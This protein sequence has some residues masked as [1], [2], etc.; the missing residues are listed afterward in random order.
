MQTMVSNPEFKEGPEGNIYEPEDPQVIAGYQYGMCVVSSERAGAKHYELSNHLGNVLAVISDHKIA[1][2]ATSD[3]LADYYLPDVLSMS[4]YYPF[5]SPMPGRMENAV[6]YRF[7]FNGQEADDEIYGNGNSYT[8]EFWQYDARLGRRWNVDPKGRP[9]ES[10]YASFANNPIIMIDPGGDSTVFYRADGTILFAM[11]STKNQPVLCVIPDDQLEAFSKAK[12]DI[13]KSKAYSSDNL[14]M[15]NYLRTLGNNYD[16]Q[17]FV[18]FYN[19]SEN[20]LNITEEKQYE[21]I[22]GKPIYNEVSAYLVSKVVNGFKLFQVGNFS[23][24]YGEGSPNGCGL[25]FKSLSVHTHPLE[26]RNFLRNGKPFDRTNDPPL[27]SNNVRATG[28]G[29][30]IGRSP[31]KKGTGLFDVNVGGRKD[32][33]L[34]NSSGTII[35]TNYDKFK[36]DV[37]NNKQ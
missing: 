31:A 28:L 37:E 13:L 16:I 33:R 9:W 23:T 3:N 4:D 26:G 22:D 29:N 8:A 18:E 17:S 34:F 20:P 25:P 5:G 10:H 2:D 15:E 12:K 21:S 30:D 36:K 19:N 14:L 35:T 24:G 6:E 7:G 27:G 32:I 11:T 1:V